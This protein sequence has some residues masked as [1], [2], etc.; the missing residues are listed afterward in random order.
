MYNFF[1]FHVRVLHAMCDIFFLFIILIPFTSFHLPTMTVA[2]CVA[3][4]GI[5]LSGIA[6][7]LLLFCDFKTIRISF[8]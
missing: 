5:H 1:Y 7:I 2:V 4:M 6:T 3:F 8:A